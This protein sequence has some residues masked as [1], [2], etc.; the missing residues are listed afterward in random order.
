MAEKKIDQ[1]HFS[2]HRRKAPSKL[3]L[4]QESFEA[5]TTDYSLG[6]MGMYIEGPPSLKLGDIVDIDVQDTSI[7]LKGKVVRSERRGKGLSIGIERVSPFSGSLSDFAVPDILLG[8]QRGQKTGVLNIKSGPVHKSVYISQ[9]DTIFSSSNQDS[10]RLGDVLLKEGRITRAQFDQSVEAMRKTGE[11]QGAV[12]V[13]LGHLKPSLLMH[14]VTYYV[15]N[16]ILSLFCMEKGS[17]EFMEGPLDTS[18]VITLKLSA[19]NLIYRGIM[20]TQNPAF[21]SSM[22]PPPDSVLDFSADPLDLFQDLQLLEA[23]KLI[24]SHID[25]NSTLSD[26]ISATKIPPDDALRGIYSLLS[27]RLIQVREK[28]QERSDISHE[29]VIAEDSPKDREMVQKINELFNE[30]R[31]LGYYGVLGLKDWATKTDIKRAYYK[32]AK[33]YHPDKHFHLPPPMKDKLNIIFSYITNAYTTLSNPVSRKEYEQSGGDTGEARVESNTKRAADRY[34]Q[35]KAALRG[36]NF[37]DAGD[38]FAEAA[39]LD[40]SKADYYFYYGLA[41]SRMKRHKE[42]E[43]ALNKALKADAFNPEYLTELGFVYLNLGFKLRAMGN[44][45]KALKIQPGDVRA[46]QGLKQTAED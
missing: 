14:A 13:K 22:C 19:A 40:S 15:E 28:G 6:G 42:A 41:L 5:E 36:K 23:E 38:F 9:G 11:R 32:R 44:F 25:G 43:K 7:K 31:Q 30:H 39:Y 16:I 34:E 45:E 29:E 18:E 35:G 33:I 26:V 17:F 8:L 46:Q 12:L 3:S 1:R 21:I 20:K 24:L 27:V 2:R 10:D 37:S 4:G